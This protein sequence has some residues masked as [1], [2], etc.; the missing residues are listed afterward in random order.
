MFFCFLCVCFSREAGEE[1]GRE[2]PAFEEVHLNHNINNNKHIVAFLY[3]GNIAIRQ[4]PSLWATIQKAV[5]ENCMPITGTSVTC[6]YTQ[7]ARVLWSQR[8]RYY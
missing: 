7:S 2:G 5:F 3:E 1:G 6:A 8:Q 4:N